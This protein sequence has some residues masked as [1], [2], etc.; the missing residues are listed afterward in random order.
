MPDISIILPVYNGQETIAE[1]LQSLLSQTFQD[2]ELCICIDGS[3]D[4]S[5]RIIANFSDQRIR[6][7]RNQE[8]FGLGRTLN[9]L[10]ALAHPSSKYIAMAEQDDFYYPERLSL[11]YQYM[12]SHS[13]VGM[14]SGIAEHFNGERVT[15]TFPGILVN[16]TNY[17]ENLVENFLLNYCYQVKVVNSCMMFRKSVHQENG[18]YFSMHYP[19]LSVDWAYI[20][21]FSLVSKIQGISKPLVRLDRRPKRNSLT[22]KKKLQFETAR[23]LIDDFYYEKK[24]IISKK[25]YKTAITTE[26][27][28]ELSAMPYIRKVFSFFFSK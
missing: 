5:E 20:L 21:R 1:T 17:P 3:D 27:L 13:D 15:F 23:Q 8:N 25:E 16:G 11:Q 19:S 4:N 12:Q 24:A 28:M 10:V 26:H 9:R 7:I 2:F 6:L 22:T 18:L 14:V